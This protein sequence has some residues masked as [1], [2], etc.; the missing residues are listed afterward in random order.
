MSVPYIQ[1]IIYIYPITPPHIHTY[2]Y[3]HIYIYTGETTLI[4]TTSNFTLYN[5][6]IKTQNICDV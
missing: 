2:T 6:L 5:N 4:R 1:Y 3:T